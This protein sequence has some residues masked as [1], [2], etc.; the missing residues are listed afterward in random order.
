MKDG[1]YCGAMYTS[2]ML[3]SNTGYGVVAPGSNE[4]LWFTVIVWIMSRLLRV[5]LIGKLLNI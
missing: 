2:M 4:E 1:S 3:I 5:L